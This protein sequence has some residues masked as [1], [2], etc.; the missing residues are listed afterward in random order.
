VEHASA[1]PSFLACPRRNRAPDN[2]RL[3][4]LTDLRPEILEASAAI[5][6][7]LKE[8]EAGWQRAQAVIADI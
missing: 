7:A 1:R 4:R 8:A 5:A 3:W 6:K 2:V